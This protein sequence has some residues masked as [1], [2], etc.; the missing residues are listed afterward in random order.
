MRVIHQLRSHL[1]GATRVNDICGRTLS[2]Q[3]PQ[4]GFFTMHANAT[5]NHKTCPAAKT[6]ANIYKLTVALA[7]STFASN[8][9]ASV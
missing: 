8:L 4:I 6:L 7:T 2:V 9:A 1:E 3:T 5:L